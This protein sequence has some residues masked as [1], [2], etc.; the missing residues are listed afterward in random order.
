[1]RHHAKV[2]AAGAATVLAV[3]AA[4]SC[5]GAATTGSAQDTAGAT[6]VT[7]GSSVPEAPGEAVAS[8]APSTVGTK[9][10]PLGKILVDFKGRTLYLFQ[11][12]RTS[13]STCTGGCAKTWPPLLVRTKPTAAGGVQGKLLSTSKRSGNATQVTYAGH[14][15]YRFSGDKKPGDTMGQGLSLFGAKWYVLGTDGKAITKMSSASPTPG[16]GY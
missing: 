7:G 15:L 9:S 4:T 1:V 8:T 11:A 2:C 5:S 10:V 6:S 16:G 12:D 14:P 3:L 13:T